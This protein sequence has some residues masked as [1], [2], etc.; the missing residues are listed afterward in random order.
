MLNLWAQTWILRTEQVGKISHVPAELISWQGIVSILTE[1]RCRIVRQWKNVIVFCG[2][3]LNS[4]YNSSF[5][6]CS[7]ARRRAVL[8]CALCSAVHIISH[9]IIYHIVS[10]RI[11]L[12]HIISYHIISYHIISHHIISHHH[13]ICHSQTSRRACPLQ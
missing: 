4:V 6:F 8:S 7:A 1:C 12:Y 2:M 5:A 11:I 13:G 9:H 3:S 10:Y